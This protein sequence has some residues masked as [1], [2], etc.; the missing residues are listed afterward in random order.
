MNTVGTSCVLTNLAETDN[1]VFHKILQ[2][3]SVC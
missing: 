3:L 1:G 2:S